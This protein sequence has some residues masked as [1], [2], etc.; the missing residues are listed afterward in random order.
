MLDKDC[1]FCKIIAGTI[2]V[3]KLFEN[4]RLLAFADI[5]PC[6]EHHYLII[7]KQHIA[8]L[9]EMNE[10]HIELFGEVVLCASRLAK[11]LGFAEEGYRIVANTNE[12]GGQTVF[13]FHLHLIAGRKLNW[14][15]G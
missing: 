13:H 6:A 8:N 3:K 10:S 9:N 11:E 2:P 1:I 7:P 14:P 4:E 12:N 5:N 15:P